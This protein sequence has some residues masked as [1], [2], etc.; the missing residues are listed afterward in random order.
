MSTH[1]FVN[2]REGPSG[3]HDFLGV[4]VLVLVEITGGGS[5]E[6]KDRSRKCGHRR[7]R[8]EGRVTVTEPSPG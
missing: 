2:C 6:V 4:Q 8:G 7:R 5:A 3:T 1:R